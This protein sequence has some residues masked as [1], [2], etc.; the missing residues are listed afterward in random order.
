MREEN[1]GSRMVGSC[2]E[3]AASSRKGNRMV[4][5]VVG[6]YVSFWIELLGWR[7]AKLVLVSLE[8]RS[9]ARITLK[10]R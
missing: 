1:A 4:P 8:M 2:C 5:G 3:G 7:K 10:G 6:W 9:A